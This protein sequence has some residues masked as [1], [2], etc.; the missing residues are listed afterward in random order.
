MF[1]ADPASLR[2]AT[3]RGANGVAGGVEVD[4]T[5][6]PEFRLPFVPPGPIWCPTLLSIGVVKQR[7]EAGALAQTHDKSTSHAECLAQSWQCAEGICQST[8]TCVAVRACMCTD[9]SGALLTFSFT[10]V[11]DMDHQM[12]RDLCSVIQDL[13]GVH[14]F[15][16]QLLQWPLG[17]HPTGSCQ[18]QVAA[19]AQPAG[20]H[21]T[22]V[23]RRESIPGFRH[24]LE[25][26]HLYAV[27]PQDQQSTS[28][29]HL[30]HGVWPQPLQLTQGPGAHSLRAVLVVGMVLQQVIAEG[31]SSMCHWRIA[32]TYNHG[33]GLFIDGWA[34]SFTSDEF[35]YHEGLVHPALLA[36][37]AP[38]RVLIGGGAELMTAKCV[39]MHSEVEEVVMVDYDKEVCISCWRHLP[40][41][42]KILKDPRL[43]V[44]HE[45]FWK[46]AQDNTGWDVVI[47]DLD[48]S[49]FDL[50][51]GQSIGD[52]RMM[53]IVRDALGTNGVLALNCGEIFFHGSS[54]DLD[55][56]I[57]LN[58]FRSLFPSAVAH[59]GW[60]PSFCGVWVWMLSQP[61][62]R[63]DSMFPSHGASAWASR[64]FLP[65]ILQTAG[66]IPQL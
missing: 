41:Y 6:V 37:P 47:S 25:S 45:D 64:S 51:R 31:S 2:H 16:F 28:I 36:H 24:E 10:G 61:P 48:D 30:I 1:P 5:G 22:K 49:C 57:G 9:L 40:G 66:D 18:I 21:L 15:T 14:E 44:L 60:V 8:L 43:T 32:S 29:H 23:T 46:Y 27:E 20:H 4:G 56:S 19:P 12:L 13:K 26:E 52:S 65:P 33:L 59:I 39:L 50:V 11:A 58:G 38:R 7:R 62:M 63:D 3:R 42:A 17:G 35:V 53:Q 34:Q 55:S 54:T